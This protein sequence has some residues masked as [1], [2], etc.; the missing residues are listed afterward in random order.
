MT[1]RPRPPD[2]RQEILDMARWQSVLALC[3]ACVLVSACGGSSSSSGGGDTSGGGDSGSGGG[4][5]QV[6][7]IR[8]GER[9]A[10]AQSASSAQALGSYTFR[11]FVDGALYGLTGVQCPGT[12]TQTGFD[13]S[14]VLPPMTAGR[15]TLELAAVVSGVQSSSSAPLLVNVSST[16]LPG[17]VP[18]T[19]ETAASLVGSDDARACIPMPSG[20]CYAARQMAG[21]LGDVGSLVSTARDEVFFIENGERVRL[22]EDGTLAA[23][24]VALPELSGARLISL[25]IPPDFD[26]SHLMFIVWAR[27]AADGGEMVGVTR[28]RELSGVLAQAATIVSG[29]PIPEGTSGAI[30]LD[31]ESNVYLALASPLVHRGSEAGG[32]IVRFTEDGTVPPTNPSSMPTV[33]AGFANPSGLAWDGPRRALLLAGTDPRLRASILALPVLPDSRVGSLQTPPIKLPEVS[34]LRETSHPSVSVAGRRD[35]GNRSLWLVLAPGMVFRATAS[36]GLDIALEAVGLDA[37]GPVTAIAQG[38]RDEDL[39]A[40]TKTSGRGSSTIWGLSPQP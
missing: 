15:H 11:L 21:E 7:T 35:A 8:G 40:V 24:S 18:L 3:W 34:G 13:C 33:S 27:P 32:Y 25:G 23:A 1:E 19:G 2:W 17:A 5:G 37:L 28:Y 39:L 31:D 9:L 4:Q 36:P 14:G 10:W 22:I 29:L 6:V 20:S 12:G 16:Q 30:A 38:A 26:R